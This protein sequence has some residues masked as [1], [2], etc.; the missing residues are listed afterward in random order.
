M[1]HTLADHSDSISENYDTKVDFEGLNLFDD[2][3]LRGIYAS[4]L[5]RPTVFQQKILKHIIHGRDIVAL[6]ASGTGKTSSLC[7]G[8]LTI[9]DR[10]VTSPQVLIV[11]SGS[12]RAVS[13]S[14]L[15]TILGTY[16]LPNP[17]ILP[18]NSKSHEDQDIKDLQRGAQI[19]LGEPMDIWKRINDSSLM[20][21]YVKL[22][23]IDDI[24][25]VMRYGASPLDI[26]EIYSTLPR[27]V[28]VVCT[29]ST[30]TDDVQD[31]IKNCM[32]DPIEILNKE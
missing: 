31:F 5:E 14:N 10:S 22:L 27:N 32:A 30:F 15:A 12:D 23:I 28:Q 19:I 2:T 8:T 7:L 20:T 4:G 17:M 26:S 6:T 13:T 16:L 25:G 21:K 1:N 11:L 18:L 3:M 29:G 9:L 24:D